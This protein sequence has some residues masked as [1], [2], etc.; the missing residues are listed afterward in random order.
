MANIPFFDTSLDGGKRS[1]CVTVIKNLG[2]TGLFRSFL[3]GPKVRSYQPNSTVQYS[4][5]YTVE[6]SE[7]FCLCLCLV[8][9]KPIMNFVNR[10]KVK[11]FG[12]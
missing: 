5:D 10:Q 12:H 7:N 3:V 6:S 8:R 9:V 11:W 4:L 2:T 1:F